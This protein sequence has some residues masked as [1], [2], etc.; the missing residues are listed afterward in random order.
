MRLLMIAFLATLGLWPSS[1]AAPA[2]K[3]YPTVTW[4]GCGA[5]AAPEFAKGLLPQIVQLERAGD[6]GLPRIFIVLPNGRTETI[7]ADEATAKDAGRINSLKVSET[8]KA[9]PGV[10]EE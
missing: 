4:I 3:E 5:E 2:P 1:E 8:F 9:K 7:L 6:D 10:R